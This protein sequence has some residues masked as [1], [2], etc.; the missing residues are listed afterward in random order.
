MSGAASKGKTVNKITFRVEFI[1]TLFFSENILS[2][3]CFRVKN[4]N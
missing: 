3:G 2:N 4:N 1:L